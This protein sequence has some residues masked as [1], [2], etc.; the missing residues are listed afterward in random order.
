MKCSVIALV[1]PILASGPL[2]IPTGAGAQD[3]TGPFAIM[4][5]TFQTNGTGT[6]PPAGTTM[7]MLPGRYKDKDACTHAVNAVLLPRF[8]PNPGNNAKT[9]LAGAFYCVPAS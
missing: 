9:T 5:V 3:F 6:V 1:A 2:L 7:M 4:A 8:E